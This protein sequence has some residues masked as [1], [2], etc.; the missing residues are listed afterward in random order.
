[1]MIYRGDTH[2]AADTPPGVIFMPRAD[3]AAERRGAA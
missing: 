2:D 1:M 3:A